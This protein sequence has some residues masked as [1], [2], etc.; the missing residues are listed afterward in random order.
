MRFCSLNEA[1]RNFKLSKLVCIS[2][3]ACAK[4]F[5]A[6]ALMLRR[7]KAGAAHSPAR[8]N[9]PQRRGL[10]HRR[11]KFRDALSTSGI[12]TRSFTFSKL[13]HFYPSFPRLTKFLLADSSRGVIPAYSHNANGK[14]YI[15]GYPIPNVGHGVLDVPPPRVSSPNLLSCGYVYILAVLHIPRESFFDYSDTVK[16]RVITNLAYQKCRARLTACAK[17]FFTP[18]LLLRREKSGAA[19]S[20]ARFIRPRRRGRSNLA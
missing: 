8:F 7:E 16:S 6:P 13:P 19:H 5:F 14:L 3:T 17:R 10:A 20:P 2:H 1:S 9:R 18:P 12:K 15:F 11:L 4:R